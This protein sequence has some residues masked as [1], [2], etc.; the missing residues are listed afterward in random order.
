MIAPFP[1]KVTLH[2]TL[3][4]QFNIFTICKNLEYICYH[5]AQKDKYPNQGINT[6]KNV[7]L[8]YCQ[9]NLK[10]SIFAMVYYAFSVMPLY[11]L[12]YNQ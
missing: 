7:L 3:D 10:A 12:F 8:R 1:Q 2:N 5:R 4:K 6:Y 9:N 11:N